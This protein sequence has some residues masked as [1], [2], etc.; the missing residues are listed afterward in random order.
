MLHQLHWLVPL[1]LQIKI[2]KV[3]AEAHKVWTRS[4]KELTESLLQQLSNKRRSIV[5]SAIQVLLKDIQ[6]FFLNNFFKNSLPLFEA[7]M[8]RIWQLLDIEPG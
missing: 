2:Q 5:L 1:W 6:F 8:L 4:P 7:A 3:E